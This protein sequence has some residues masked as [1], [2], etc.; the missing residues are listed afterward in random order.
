MRALKT[1]MHTTESTGIHDNIIPNHNEYE[2]LLPRQ[3]QTQLFIGFLVL[4]NCKYTCIA[5]NSLQLQKLVTVKSLQYIH[6][7]TITSHVIQPLV[8]PLLLYPY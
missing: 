1:K 2:I 5:D 7:Q 3:D 4:H 6:V 8:F